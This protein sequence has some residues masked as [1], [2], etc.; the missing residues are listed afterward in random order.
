MTQ[1]TRSWL[2]RVA[3]AVLAPALAMSALVVPA[4]A[5]GADVAPFGPDVSRWQHPN[6]A[7]I[8]WAQVKAGGSSF[9]IIKATE[10]DSYTNPYLGN[11]AADARSN[12]LAVGAYHYARPALP[13]ST[14]ADQAQRF[15]VVLGESLGGVQ[16]AATLPPILDL[17]TTGGLSS[18][19]LVTWAQLFTET[20]RTATGRT[21]V[22]YTYISFW[23]V[24]MGGSRAFSQ[25][26]L[27]LAAYR[28]TPPDPVGGWPAFTLWQYTASARIPGIS[29]DVDMSRF[30]GDAAAYA[31]FTDGTVPTDWTVTAP[32]APVNV[33][34]SAGV[35]SASVR[36]LPSDDGGSLPT[37]YTV[38]ASPGGASVTRPG[39]STQADFTGLSAG[40]SY[41]FTVTATNVAGSS[42]QSRGSAPV[43]ARG[44]APGAPEYL[45]A[46]AG[47]GSVA[48]TWPAVTTTAGGPATSYAVLRCAPTPCTPSTPVATVP[49]PAASYVDD[50]VTGGVTYDYAVTAANTWGA[51]APS[52]VA[53][54]M[55][56]PVVDRLDTPTGLVATGAKKSLQ[57]VWAPVQFAARYQVLRCT[58]AACVPGTPVATV[59][60]PAARLSQ[61]VAAGSTYTYAVRA[62][63]GPV[64]SET[65]AA[66]T[67]TALIP[68][69]LRLSVSAA[70]AEVGRPI[71]VSVR[72]TRA[73]TKVAMADRKVTLVFT[74]ARGAAPAPIDLRTSAAG[75]ASVLVTPAVNQMVTARSSARDLQSARTSLSV[76][77]TPVLVATLSAPAVAPRATVALT[78]STS[79]LFYGE[80]V[81]RQ[82]RSASSW[83]TVGSVP[84]SRTGQYR[85]TVAAAAG[86]GAQV[87]RV[88]IGRT[89]RHLGAVSAP[90]TLTTR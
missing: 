4:A 71:R 78:G 86:P 27:W 84:V 22:I 87:I 54:A 35:R 32:T 25:F 51:S 40:T 21:P 65:S 44:D 24:Q 56:L 77:V 63:A 76:R 8:D 89:V 45:T 37:S 48:L 82:V 83:R 31:E 70:G 66:V 46:T 29:S 75:E 30:A 73:D 90:L 72:L 80:R 11:D 36:W 18:A 43:V 20:L 81:L 58:G 67:G 10:G 47:R 19:Q 26:P 74:P 2:R 38:T 3:T 50:T 12:Q 15:A 33:K 6:G 53:E 59:D 13:M 79:R 68:Q 14:A 28:S 62:V 64:T 52:P 1:L 9:A 88:M 41:A 5:A 61:T 57:V 42:A 16:T 69:S 85:F 60:A 17:E 7:P 34:A 39:T 55:P 23:N 49:V